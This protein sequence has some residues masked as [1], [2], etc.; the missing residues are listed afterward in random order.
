MASRRESERIIAEGRVCVNGQIV[1][2]MGYIVSEDDVVEVDGKRILPLSDHVYILYYKPMGEIS[3]A[4]DPEGRRTVIDRFA[5]LNRRLY[6]VG[7]LDYDTQ[8]LLLITDD[9]EFMQ[10]LTHPSQE[11][12]KTYLALVEGMPNESLLRSLREGVTI[13]EG[14]K[15]APAKVRT[16]ALPNHR[17][18]ITITIHEGKNRQ[19]RR[20]L[21]AIGY[22]A[23]RLSRVMFA[24]LTMDGL[25]PGKYRHLTREEVARLMGTSENSIPTSF[26]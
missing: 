5:H 9:G 10:K 11:I 8:G 3:T 12:A 7:R 2:T 6:P 17:T 21:E 13:D 22:P 24:D 18:E 1:D 25:S 26:R 16:R 20:M 4:K 15:T 23:I 14:V 19:V